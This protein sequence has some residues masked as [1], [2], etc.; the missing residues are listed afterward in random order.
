[1]AKD[2]SFLIVYYKGKQY[3]EGCVSSISKVLSRTNL[4]YEIIIMDNE[5]T[6]VSKNLLNHL[7]CSRNIRVIDAGINLGYGK[8]NNILSDLANSEVLFFLNQDTQMLSLCKNHI[9]YI[10]DLNNVSVI[11]P[12]VLN[13]DKST[14]KNIFRYPSLWSLFFEAIFIKDA[15]LNSRS[16]KRLL[17]RETCLDNRIVSMNRYYPSGAAFIINKNVFNNFGRFDEHIFMYHEEC[18]MFQRLATQIKA[19]LVLCRDTVLM[20]YGGRSNFNSEKLLAE[21]WGNLI[22][23]YKK[24]KKGQALSAIQETAFKRLILLSLSLRINMLK[25]GINIPYSPTSR[26][27]N[28]RNLYPRTE[29]INT[30]L[31]AKDIIMG[32]YL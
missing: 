12:K 6:S 8:A 32:S 30:L 9:N 1:M 26:L 23:V 17:S 4:D 15:L 27:Y 2:I 7:P 21:Y 25:A 3:I 13:E 14:Q 20:H 5:S 10:K 22:Y 11:V 31:K 18:E 28:D 29:T 16:I 24:R 19:N